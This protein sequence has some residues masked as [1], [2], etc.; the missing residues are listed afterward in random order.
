[1]EN[2]HTLEI[3]GSRYQLQAKFGEGGMGSVYRALDRLTGETVAVKRVLLD[4]DNADSEGMDTRIAL[5]QEFQTLASLRH[6]HIITVLDYGFDNQQQP[7]FV[8]PLLENANPFHEAAQRHSDVGKVNL[9]IQ[10]LQALAYLHRRGIIH[11]DLKPG[12]VL[13]TTDDNVN[14][15]DFG[16]AID[17]EEATD[18]AGTLMYM[19][20]EILLEQ[21]ATHLSDLY[22]AGTMAYEIFTGHHPFVNDN[23]AITI[24]NI[25]AAPPD[26]FDVPEIL[27]SVEPATGAP[28]L[29]EVLERLLEKQPESRYPDAYAVIRDLSACAGQ[30]TPEESS[31]IRESYLQAASFIG[32]D[33]EIATL[34]D[35][36]NRTFQGHGSRWLVGGESGVGKSRLL[37]ELRTRALVRGAIVLRGQE[38]ANGRLAYLLWREP[39]RRLLLASE[40]T[41]LQASI[42]KELVPDIANIL[43]RP[44][45][46]A[47]ALADGD[48]V[49]E[50]LIL[51]I[52]D[53][54]RQQKKPV[55]LIL[56]DLH[57]ATD[58]LEVIRRINRL[59]EQHPI[60]VIGSF[61]ND[62]KPTLPHELS[63]M[64]VIQLERLRGDA[65]AA[66]SA[67]MLGEI[68]AQPQII[69]LLERETEG[70]IF[71]LV[72]T[73]R[74]LAEEAGGLENIGKVTIPEHVFAGGVRQIVERRLSHVPEMFM[75]LLNVA[76]VAGRE[77]D[78]K[79]LAEIV[80]TSPNQKIV[81]TDVD[82][83]LTACANIAVFVNWDSRWRFAHDKLREI[84]VE[85]LTEIERHALHRQVAEVIE[86]IYPDDPEQAIILTDHWHEAN[87]A[88]KEAHYARI[89]SERLI[90]GD[91]NKIRQALQLCE[92][93]TVRLET[94]ADDGL[95]LPLLNLIGQA[96]TA[97]GQ[98]GAAK[99]TYDMSLHIAQRLDDP[100]GIA[101]ALDGLGNVADK[102]GDYAN[103][104]TH[105]DE[106][107][108]Y[109][110]IAQDK[111]AIGETLNGL[112]TIAAK[113]GSLDEA[114]DYFQQALT[115]RREI[116]DQKG[117]AACLNN[118]GIVERFKGNLTQC[119]AY[120]E[121]ALAL[122]RE[123][124]DKRGIAASLNNLGILARSMKDFDAAVNY[125][126]ESTEIFRAIG[127]ITGIA[128]IYNN[129][130]LLYTEQED[131][132]D[133]IEAFEETLDIAERLGD[134]RAIANALENLGNVAMQQENY[135]Q[136]VNY[137]EKSLEASRKMGDKRIIAATQ[138]NMGKALSALGRYMQAQGSFQSALDLFHEMNDQPAVI[139]VECQLADI[140]LAHDEPQNALPHLKNAL[141]IASKLE[142]KNL[143][144]CVILG[145]AD[146]ATYQKR[147]T[148]AAKLLGYVQSRND[149]GLVGEVE[150]RLAPLRSKVSIEG[151]LQAGKGLS[152]AEIISHLNQLP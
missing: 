54:F 86:R 151:A 46:D 100:K 71:F 127:D 11:R 61:R 4:K 94:A 38:V 92:R 70:N 33:A 89:A 101:A 150:S 22:A 69:Q 25:V 37:D 142:Q 114:A 146:Y 15:L 113:R 85:R 57:W 29:P 105:F 47:P 108:V 138:N 76:A 2:Q 26:M 42:L 67:S 110:R 124:D 64:E 87:D 7:Y 5:A 68:G 53:L 55:V 103:A 48:K 34:S 1:V 140:I 109:S 39:I 106:A 102:R 16:L 83:W 121:Q 10:M 126:S 30:D 31:A 36:L 96:Y 8:M 129:L 133:A 134:L 99:A 84:L 75:P 45:E 98:Y 80:Q 65:I 41:D 6:P 13:V 120:Y 63:T 132:D 79:L 35:A 145:Y 28:L 9:L 97:T 147:Y 91:G 119:R 19:A 152:E 51:T 21:G 135:Q 59:T 118:L 32:R 136:S 117:V 56:E 24:R 40:L 141:D 81:Q 107:L 131:Y 73:V 111:N 17:N 90:H 112:G 58:S 18:M 50:R 43:N 82:D 14:V 115:L 149:S 12:N 123:I 128:I 137:Y 139:N 148:D 3:I 49:N 95:R 144:W 122:R 88:K 27:G 23:P 143:L 20:P 93:A 52:T 77:L 72:E 44:V 60:L 74:A 78:F 116:N 62:E 66:L 125:Y 104:K 130:G